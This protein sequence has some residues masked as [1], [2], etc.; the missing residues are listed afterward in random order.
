MGPAACNHSVPAA[1]SRE[2]RACRR[3]TCRHGMR[4]RLRTGASTSQ[5][6][7][8]T[9]CPGRRDGRTRQRLWSRCTQGRAT[10]RYAGVS[11]GTLGAGPRSAPTAAQPRVRRRSIGF[12]NPNGMPRSGWI[13]VKRALG[14][15]TPAWRG[16]PDRGY[17]VFAVCAARLESANLAAATF[18]QSY[19]LQRVVMKR[20]LLHI[21]APAGAGHPAPGVPSA[22]WPGAVRAHRPAT[23]RG[24]FPGLWRTHAQGGV[25]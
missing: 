8:S 18:R 10:Q 24:S 7:N 5:H 17:P 9:A 12:P 16:T 6:R 13:V 1:R 20:Y 23:D 11:I 14:S 22:A 2:H 21:H 4:Q 19:G 3:R 15:A 25:T